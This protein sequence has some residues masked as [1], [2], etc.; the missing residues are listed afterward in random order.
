VG[1]TNSTGTGTETTTV[2]GTPS[3]SYTLSGS[4]ASVSLKNMETAGG[5]ARWSTSGDVSA[6]PLTGASASTLA[7]N[8]TG[9]TGTVGGMVL[10]VGYKVLEA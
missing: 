8:L 3:L 2:P 4:A 6:I 10:A 5:L 7:V 9:T 1:A